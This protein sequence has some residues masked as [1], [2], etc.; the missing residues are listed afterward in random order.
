LYLSSRIADAEADD[1][2]VRLAAESAPSA[3][4]LEAGDVLLYDSSLFHFGG[5]NLSQLPRALLMFSFQE[6][7]P[8]GSHEEVQGFTYHYHHSILGKLTL[9]SFA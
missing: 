1:A 4:V 9:G 8:W 6:A 3:A 7:T 5:A 2:A